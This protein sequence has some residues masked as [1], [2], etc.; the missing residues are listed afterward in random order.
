MKKILVLG[1]TG[2]VGGRLVPRLLKRGYNVRC[3]VRDCRKITGKSWAAQVEV[4]EG[5]VLKSETLSAAFRDVEVVYYLVHSMVSGEKSFEDLDR[6]AALN[7]AAAAKEANVKRIVYLGG[8]GRREIEQSPHLRSRHEVG[9]VLR[10]GTVPVTEFRAAVIVGSGSVSFEMVHHLVNRLPA[11]ICPRWVL[12]RTQP[13]AI[14]DVLR[15]LI[16]T[17]EKPESYGKTFDIGGPEVLTYRDMMLTVAR[18]LGFKRFLIRVPVLTPRL[19]SYWVNL[20]TPVPAQVARALI[21]GVRYETVVENDEA[22]EIFGFPP[23]KYEEAVRRALASVTAHDVETAWTD[24]FSIFEAPSVDPSHLRVDLREVAAAVPAEKLFKVVTSI[25]GDNGWYFANWLW[26]LRGFIDQQLGGVGLRRGRRHPEKIAVGDALD[27][28]R[29]EEYLEG[30]KLLLRA[31][32]KVWGRAWLE[33]KVERV[34]DNNSRLIQT[35]R[36]YPRGLFG[37]IYWYAVYPVHALVFRGMS[38]AVARRAES[39]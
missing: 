36:Y 21:E 31:E 26:Q 23:M 8:L 18:V 1:A 3:L 17:I 20:V 16:D 13:I 29:V 35:A 37:L 34:D 14:A 2:Y 33:F 22:L 19:S 9:E 24:A 5:D 38:R 32:M 39:L 11:M 6:K 30:E 25:G 15:Y 12:T 10:S 7:V 4:F 27:F 28:W